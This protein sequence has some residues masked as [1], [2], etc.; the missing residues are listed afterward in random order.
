MFAHVDVN[1]FYASCE[2]VFR[3]DL[4][5]SPVI[6][7]SNNDGCVIA[8][9]SEAKALGIKM[10]QPYFKLSESYLKHYNIQ[11]FSSNYALYGDL[12]Q[13]VMDTIESIVPDIEIY[14]I[15]EAFCDI[16]SF[17]QIMSFEALGQ[18]IRN[19]VK[20]CT[21]LTVGVGIGQ[22]KTLAKLANY[23]A[24]NWPKTGGVVDLSNRERQIKLMAITPIEEVWGIGRAI[25]QQLKERNIQTALDLANWS[26]IEAKQQF[27]VVLERTIRELNGESCLALESISEPRQQIVCSRSF[28]AK[29]TDIDTLSQAISNYTARAA[30][31]LREDKQ[32]CKHITVFVKT[33]PFT[34]NQVYYSNSSSEKIS[35]T[36]DTRKLLSVANRL[37]K[38]I[39]V[40]GKNYQKAGVILNDF[41]QTET[42]QYDLLSDSTSQ[43]RNERLLNTID[44]INKTSSAKL[45]FASQGIKGQW[46]M[47]QEF[48]SPAYTTRINDIPIVKLI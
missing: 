26:P 38:Q 46:Q 36:S 21:H 15:D 2:K 20:Q 19:E 11:V 10:G 41:C 3:T 27:S 40:D 48:L 33:S 34:P 1:S 16:A 47:K 29:V 5:A 43:V 42:D 28:G 45:F 7:L 12:S 35:A 44:R 13:R 8:R 32:Y 24:K 31:K 18:K 37:L 4:K 23:A 25:S 22:T 14:S 6:V 30:E 9:S 17:N 39:W